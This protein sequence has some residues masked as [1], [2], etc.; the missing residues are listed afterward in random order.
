M[1][2]E[3]QELRF[4]METSVPVTHNLTREAHGHAHEVERATTLVEAIGDNRAC[5]ARTT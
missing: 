4:I 2:K 3:S 5:F 1:E